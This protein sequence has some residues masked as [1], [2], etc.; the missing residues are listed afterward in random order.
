MIRQLLTE[1]VVLALAGG[2]AGVLV[3]IVG[4]GAIVSIFASGPS[5]AII[6]ASIN[7][8]VLAATAAVVLVTATGVGLVPAFRATR[9]DL[10]P[11]LKDG[12]AAGHSPYRPRLGKALVVAQIAVSVVLVTA[13]ILLSRSLQK[14]HSFDAGFSREQVVLADIDLTGARLPPE[15]KQQAFADLDQRLRAF[16]EVQAVSL[17]LR[18]P[19]DF[20]LQLRR[21][22]V[23]GVP[24]SPR[25]GV[26]SNQ[27][28]PGYFRTFGMHLVRGRE[29]TATDGADAPSVA[30]KHGDGAPLLRRG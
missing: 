7:A 20:S 1:S 21:I 12:M 23:P 22:D 9:L 27:V 11:A 24:P 5:P 26:S 6:D 14:L 13:A 17:S 28:S 29:F 30:V 15:V 25:N 8:R 2:A 19:L 4:S 10:A 16:G 18:T 3:A